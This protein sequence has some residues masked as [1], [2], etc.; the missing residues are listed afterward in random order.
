[1]TCTMRD[2]L[3]HYSWLT[4]IVVAITAQLLGKE[5]WLYPYLAIVAALAI[6]VAVA[7]LIHVLVKIY[8]IW[9][10]TEKPEEGDLVELLRELNREPV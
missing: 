5:S 2:K 8:L 3:S 4:T 1:M 9:P 7:T 6:L 10:K